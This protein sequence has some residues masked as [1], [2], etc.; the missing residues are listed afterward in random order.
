MKF[1]KALLIIVAAI[2]LFFNFRVYTTIKAPAESKSITKQFNYFE[3]RIKNGA[4][5][6]MQYVFPEGYYFT[7]L[8]YGLAWVE[9]A[10]HTTGNDSIRNKAFKESTWALDNL[11][12]ENGIAPFKRNLDLRP[13]YG[14]FYYCWT[15]YLRAK[16]IQSFASKV[17]TAEV[18]AFKTACKHIAFELNRKETPY[19]R[20]YP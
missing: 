16:R 10:N 2:I 9:Y 6:N 11:E 12:S 5:I 13:M 18:T 19:L 14:A 20:S 17:D 15:N 3:E 1:Y 7:N 4:A 8:L